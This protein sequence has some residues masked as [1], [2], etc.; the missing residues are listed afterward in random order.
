MIIYELKKYRKNKSRNNCLDFQTFKQ[1]VT[2]YY[3][4][5]IVYKTNF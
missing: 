1:N 5:N 3:R 4:Y 2:F